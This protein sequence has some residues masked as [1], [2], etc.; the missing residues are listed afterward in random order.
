MDIEPSRVMSH[1]RNKVTTEEHFVQ[2]P[3]H[4]STLFISKTLE[5]DV[6]DQAGG[7]DRALRTR[8]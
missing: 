3:R 6:S 4:R 7:V 2:S 1:G 8:W 5:F